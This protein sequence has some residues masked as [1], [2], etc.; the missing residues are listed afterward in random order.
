MRSL[1]KFFSLVAV[2]ASFSSAKADTIISA[3]FGATNSGDA[4][5]PYSGV[6]ASAVQFDTE[7]SQTDIW[8]HLLASGEVHS[9]TVTF[10]NLVS[11][12][13]GATGAT[14]ST[15]A[16]G[17]YNA[18]PNFPGTYFYSAN[19]DSRPFSL[20]G[21]AANTAFTL[22]IYAN[23]S[24]QE[25]PV[26]FSIGGQTASSVTARQDDQFVQGAPNAVILYLTGVTSASGTINGTWEGDDQGGVPDFP[27]VD[28]AGFQLDLQTPTSVTPE[29]GSLVLLATGMLG[30]AGAARRRLA[31]K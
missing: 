23:D 19:G 31:R 11:S 4:F 2:V 27:E 7:F 29:P 1:L 26:E 10:A 30:V 8:N 12:T 18:A 24:N 21:L 9:R 20:T 3:Q 22:L 25:R 13:G 6:E 16:D 17:A 15:G 5:V 14:F 28:W